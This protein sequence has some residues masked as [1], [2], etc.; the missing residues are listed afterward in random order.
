M[1]LASVIVPFGARPSSAEQDWLA[2]I[3]ARPEVG[4]VVVT[5]PE[6][7]EGLAIP[8]TR[9]LQTEGGRGT[10][11]KA[12]VQSTKSEQ[13]ILQDPD[14]RYSALDYEPLLAPLRQGDAEA[15]YGNRYGSE[16]AVGSFFGAAGDRGL[17]FVTSAVTNLALSDP[18][19]GLKAFNGEALRSLSLTS[20]DEGVDAEITFKLAAQF[21]RIYEVALRHSQAPHHDSMRRR[22]ASA[23]PLLRYAAGG[24]D[25]ANLHEGYNTLLRMDGA[26]HYNAWLGRKI[27]G[28]LGRRVLEVGAGI[29]TITRQIEKGRELVVALEVDKFY[30][31]KLKNLFHDKPHVLPLLSG[32]EDA[33]WAKLKVHRLDTVVLSNVLEHIPDD[34]KAVANFKSLLPPGGRLIILVP[35]LP[36]LFGTIDD[37]VGHYRRYTPTTLRSVLESQGFAVEHLEWMN[38]VGIPGWFLN[39]R[40]FKRRAV[41][42]LQLAVYDRI[43][44]LLA[45]AEDRLDLP[46]GMSLLAVARA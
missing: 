27:R 9:F 31:E 16:R 13:V 15:V 32:V 14:P 22:M 43:A 23:R 21:Y 8:K 10:A 44:P 17:K 6:G 2:T 38:L 45:A 33:D 26:P 18:D 19:C 25:A 24:N 1:S 20:P 37:A 28:H 42:A 34:A 35:A 3:A 36:V 39:G 12:A 29:G 11:L 5:S 7:A 40:I 4:E 30:V 41:P 46:V